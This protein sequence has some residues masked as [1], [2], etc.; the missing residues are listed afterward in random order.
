MLTL[1]LIFMLFG[2]VTIP[3][4]VKIDRKFKEKAMKENKKVAVTPFIIWMVAMVIL[5]SFVIGI[6]IVQ[7]NSAIGNAQSVATFEQRDI[8]Y[9]E[10]N[11]IY[12]TVETNDWEV[13][14]VVSKYEIEKETALDV[15]NKYSEY[16]KLDKEL[17][18]FFGVEQ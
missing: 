2:F 15:I 9:D 11:D 1:I 8:Y 10:V 17:S 7:K 12:F 5:S 16:N 3:F 14:P 6:P 18:E 13:F 4:M